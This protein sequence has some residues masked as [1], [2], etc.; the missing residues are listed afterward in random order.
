MGITAPPLHLSADK[1]TVIKSIIKNYCTS[2]CL[3]E[4]RGVQKGMS[5]FGV[6]IMLFFSVSQYFF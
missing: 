4:I 6:S 3:E 2:S 1:D 5:T